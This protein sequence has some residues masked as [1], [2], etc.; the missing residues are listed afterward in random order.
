M[1]DRQKDG[2]EE[3]R[4]MHLHC[5]E[6]DSSIVWQFEGRGTMFVSFTRTPHSAGKRKNQWLGERRRRR[7]REEEIDG[8]RDIM[9]NTPNLIVSIGMCIESS[10]KEES[11]HAWGKAGGRRVGG[12]REKESKDDS[13]S[14]SECRK[15]A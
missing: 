7:R 2:R 6:I 13:A 14:S 4:V 9:K 15:R 12:K 10:A 1:T 8:R 11:P 3:S 5:H